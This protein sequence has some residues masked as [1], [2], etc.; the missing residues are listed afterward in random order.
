M[1]R[2]SNG[3]HR[4]VIDKHSKEQTRARKQRLREEAVRLTLFGA[5]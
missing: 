5:A 2:I 1:K 4:T 3:E